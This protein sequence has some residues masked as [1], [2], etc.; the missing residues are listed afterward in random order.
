MKTAEQ[1]W[2]VYCDGNTAFPA[3]DFSHQIAFVLKNRPEVLDAIVKAFL[4][5]KPN[6]IYHP[7]IGADI[8]VTFLPKEVYICRNETEITLSKSE[9]VHFLDGVDKVY[10]DILPLG[11]LVEIDKEQLS[12]ELVASLLGDEP[13]YVMIMGRK[14]V[15]DG[16]YVDYLAQFWPLGFQ[17]D[18]PPMA[19]HKTMIKRIIAQ[20]Y[21]ESE[22]ESSYVGQLRKILMKTDIPSHFYL[23]LQEELDDENQ[24]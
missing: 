11:T 4:D 23:R 2:K 10:S 22:K 12:Q 1:I 5:K 15:F 7:R 13:L 8:E 3:T 24:A 17:A 16:A 14:V 6:Y 21:A 20:G 18:L 19:I 9:F